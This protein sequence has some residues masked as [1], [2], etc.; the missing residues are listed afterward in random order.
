MLAGYVGSMRTTL[1]IDEPILDELKRRGR[2]QH[3]SLGQVVSEL[4]ATALRAEGRPPPAIPA[5]KWVTKPMGAKVDLADHDAVLDAM[6][7][8]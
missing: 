4:A 2:A 6:D 3:K 5:Y 1:D 7:K 8:R